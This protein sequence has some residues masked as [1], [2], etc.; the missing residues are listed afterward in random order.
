MSNV[1]SSVGNV[2]VSS[3]EKK[4]VSNKAL[5]TILHEDIFETSQAKITKGSPEKPKIGSALE[6]GLARV[7]AKQLIEM[8][9]ID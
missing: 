7:I 1:D 4:S 8:P 3:H 2:D 6:I 5:L 9:A